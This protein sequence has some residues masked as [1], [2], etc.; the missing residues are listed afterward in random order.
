MISHR[1]GAACKGGKIDFSRLLISRHRYRNTDHTLGY[2]W[3]GSTYFLLELLDDER[4]VEDLDELRLIRADELL[5]EETL[6]LE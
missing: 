5:D 4:P 2:F 1:I 3:Y 6:P